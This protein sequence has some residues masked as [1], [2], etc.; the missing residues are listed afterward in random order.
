MR[1]NRRWARSAVLHVVEALRFSPTRCAGTTRHHRAGA[2]VSERIFP[3]LVHADLSRPARP[4]V[5]NDALNV[6][7]QGH[8]RVAKRVELRSRRSRAPLEQLPRNGAAA[9]V[10]TSHRASLSSSRA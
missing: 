4:D 10:S 6:L 9:M 5:V 7:L 1:C 2:R 3:V 8:R